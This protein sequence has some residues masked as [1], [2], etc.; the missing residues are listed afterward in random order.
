MHY[1]PAKLILEDG[2]EYHCQSFGY[3]QSTAGELCFSTG[4]VGYTESISDPSYCGQI[5]I[6]SY[7][8]IGNYGIPDYQILNEQGLLKNFESDS[9]A[10]QAIVVSDYS[11]D[12]S[13]HDGVKSLQDWLIE[14][15]ITAVTNID[16]RALTIKIRDHGAMLAK[17]EV[18]GESVEF[19]N[20]NRENLVSKVSIDKPITYGS[21]STKIVLIDCGVKN[22]I[23]RRLLAFDTTVIRVPWDYDYHTHIREY[24]GIVVSNGPGNPEFLGTTIKYLKDSV[25][26]KTPIFGI[27]LGHQLLALAAGGSTYKMKFGHRSH[28]Q[29]T[30][31]NDNNHCYLTSQNHGFAVDFKSLPVGW[32]ESFNNLNDGSNEG[33]EH[34]SSLFFS[35]QFH[36]EASSGPKDT[37]NLFNRFIDTITKTKEVRA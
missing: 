2:T 17:I 8:L 23:I 35:V 18:G 28:N 33:I 19:Y 30:F 36:P 34:Q 31:W 10:L 3:H 1:K 9:I 26:R 20:P 13:H 11:E 4:M 37:E 14:H 6:F 15:K 12:Y 27:C 21:G 7:P 16:T 32:K 25:E 22:N 24:D 29:P 5:L